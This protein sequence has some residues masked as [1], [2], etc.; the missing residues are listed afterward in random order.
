VSGRRAA[1]GAAQVAVSCAFLYLTL[2]RV[3]LC[4]VWQSAAKVD[5]WLLAT[6]LLLKLTGFGLMT[7]RTRALSSRIASLEYGVIFKSVLVA[8]VGNNVL[9][10]R[11][12][13]V[14]RVLYLRSR[15]SLSASAGLGLVFLE[16]VLDAL[17]LALLALACFPL[18][19]L[20]GARLPTL[21]AF[22][23]GVAAATA[24]LLLVS[25][26]PGQTAGTL[27]WL[28]RPLGQ[29]RADW[30]GARAEAFAGGLAGFRSLATLAM[31]VGCTVGF[32]TCS[33][34]GFRLWMTA[35]GLQLAWYAP[36]LVLVYVSAGVVLPAAPGFVGTYHFFLQQSLVSLG[37]GVET[38]TAFAFVGHFVAVVP[39]TVAAL[40]VVLSD[41]LRL[42]AR[43]E[44]PATTAA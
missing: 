33:A 1:I 22:A 13:E 35:F 3:D 32:W 6:S 42:S 14:M 17:A 25:R 37:V 40:P 2:R 8:F 27:R 30:I 38:A 36:L 44:D 9:P 12:G 34:L 21:F 26:R 29:A 28:A 4:L 20:R 24:G 39:F 16:R 15:S 7:L 5:G 10:F 41:I 43:R 11:L 31:S 18:L 19:L 23:L